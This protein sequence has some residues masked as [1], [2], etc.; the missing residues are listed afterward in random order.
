MEVIA[1]DPNFPMQPILSSLPYG[2]NLFIAGIFST[3]KDGDDY[4]NSLDSDTRD[5][6]IKHS[7]EFRSRADIIDCVNRLHEES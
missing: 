6:V 7:D 1:I 3:P 2:N 5:Y 4:L